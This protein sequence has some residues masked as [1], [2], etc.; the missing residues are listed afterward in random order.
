ME[1]THPRRKKVLSDRYR[2]IIPSAYKN[3]QM[4]YILFVALMTPLLLLPTQLYATELFYEDCKETGCVKAYISQKSK[5]AEGQYRITAMYLNYKNRGS[6]TADEETK[7]AKVNC[8]KTIATVIWG[9][10]KPQKIDKS[11][12]P[13]ATSDKKVKVNS[14]AA[15]K[16]YDESTSL[17]KATCPVR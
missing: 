3:T 6:N 9:S 1:Q 12:F 5:I 4:R 10:N 8:D 13:K 14:P 7:T 16:K 15:I 17:W 2:T 11:V